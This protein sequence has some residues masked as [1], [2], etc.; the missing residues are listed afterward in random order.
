MSKLRLFDQH[1]KFQAALLDQTVTMYYRPGSRLYYIPTMKKRLIPKRHGVPPGLKKGSG[2][3]GF[4]F[5]PFSGSTLPNDLHGE[6]LRYLD[7]NHGIA[8]GDLLADARIIPVWATTEDWWINQK[9]DA[10]HDFGELEKLR[11]EPPEWPYAPYQNHLFKPSDPRWCPPGYERCDET[12]PHYCNGLGDIFS[13]MWYH[14]WYLPY[15]REYGPRIIDPDQRIDYQPIR[16]LPVLYCPWCG[17][18]LPKSLRPE[19]EQRVRDA[20]FDPDNPEHP[21]FPPELLT[22]DW[23]RLREV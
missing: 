14:Y 16:I 11:H 20:G 22:G 18:E 10:N 21:D 1:P 12:P 5:C 13:R 4:Q 6:R 15:T 2:G 23:W 17:T 9:I 3:Y 7:K 8:F 19:W